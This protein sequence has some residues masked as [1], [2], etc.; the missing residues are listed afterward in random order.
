MEI[1]GILYAGV[2]LG[3]VAVM[4]WAVEH[5]PPLVPHTCKHGLAWDD[6]DVCYFAG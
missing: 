5:T 4:W 6:C 2:A 1:M 3:A